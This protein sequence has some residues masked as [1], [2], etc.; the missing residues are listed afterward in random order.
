M[1]GAHPN[2]QADS[3]DYGQTLEGHQRWPREENSRR[4]GYQM[5]RHICPGLA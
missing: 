4:R 3:G 1:R 2:G 5:L